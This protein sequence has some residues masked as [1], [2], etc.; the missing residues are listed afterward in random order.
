MRKNLLFVFVSV[1]LLGCSD[2]ENKVKNVERA[3]YYWKDDSS[4]EEE[5]VKAINKLEVKKIYYKFFEIDYNETMGNFPYQKNK[6]NEYTLKKL[7]SVNLVPT[8]FIRNEIFQYN[9]EKSL[10]K[11][12][13]NIVF[14]IDKYRKGY[15][16]KEFFDYSEI[17]IDCDWTKSTKEK[18]FYLLRKIK[19]LSK[20]EISC[21]LRL[22]PYKYPDIMGVP[23]VDKA[24]LMCYNLIKPLSQKDKNSILDIDELKSYLDKKRDYPV[25]LDVALPVFYWT[26]WY[27]NNRFAG[28]VNFNS[29]DISSIAKQTK[30]MWYEMTEDYTLE[31]EYYLKKGDQLKFEELNAATINEAISIIK[32]NVELDDT[33]TISLFHLDNSTFKKYNHEEVSSFYSSF[34][35]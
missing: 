20:K 15:D 23:P 16:E 27:H 1:L 7:D 30:P 8:V 12:A 34:T 2:K 28:L 25:H 10:D 24:T 3:F 17:Q 18:Y 5:T 31:Y 13:D 6:P 35:K 19:E 21:T 9:D 32:K 4:F 14:L 26:L 22:Y 11:L 29:A 33:T